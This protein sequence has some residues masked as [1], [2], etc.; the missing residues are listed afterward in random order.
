MKKL[1]FP[2]YVFFQVEWYVKVVTRTFRQQHET[3][4]EKK[5]VIMYIKLWCRSVSNTIIPKWTK[6]QSKQSVISNTCLEPFSMSDFPWGRQTA[7]SIETKQILQA[8]IQK[9]KHKNSLGDIHHFPSDC[10]MMGVQCSYP[11]VKIPIVRIRPLNTKE[12][13]KGDLHKH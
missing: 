1:S 13:L 2:L 5:N 6:A 10:P 3:R 11:K 9:Q 8:A 7:N 12:V 4:S